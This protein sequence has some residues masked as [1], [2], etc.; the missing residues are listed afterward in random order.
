MP[1]NPNR[2]RKRTPN[3]T[4]AQMSG[5]HINDLLPNY[6]YRGI[7]F[8]VRCNNCNPP[9]EVDHLCNCPYCGWSEIVANDF[10]GKEQRDFIRFL[11]DNPDKDTEEAHLEIRSRR[12]TIFQGEDRNT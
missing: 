8:L 9:R 6:R 10:D 7:L 11:R 2:D 3:K 5:L 12:W 4:S 1:A